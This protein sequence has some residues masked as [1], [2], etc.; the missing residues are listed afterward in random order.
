MDNYP[1]II[2]GLP[3]L[4]LDFEYHQFDYDH[5]REAIYNDCSEEDKRLIEWLDFGFDEKNLSPHFYRASGKCKNLFIKEFFSFDRL[6][7]NEKV[8]FLSGKKTDSEFEEKSMVQKVF[9]TKNIIEREKQLDS[10]MWNYANSII[11]FEFFNINVILS[12][13]VKA[14]IISRWNK[15]DK[16][17]GEELFG[18]LVD[19]VRG[20][21]KGVEFNEQK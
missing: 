16:K 20:T 13:L 11:T 2:A 18:K 1:Y 15:L 14:R 12:F 17:T 3:D 10:L 7:R 8:A 19:E 9:E 4:T 6:V 5:V 21:F